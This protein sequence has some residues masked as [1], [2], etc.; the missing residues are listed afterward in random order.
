MQLRKLAHARCGDKGNSVNIVVIA[1]NRTDYPRLVRALTTDRVRAH[2]G[3]IVEGPVER[4][5]VPDLGVLNFVVRDV[6]GGGVTRSLRL[7]PHGKTLSSVLL[8]LE[9]DD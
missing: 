8:A 2:L 4:H 5:L 7:D 1:H 9:I 3:G 6:L